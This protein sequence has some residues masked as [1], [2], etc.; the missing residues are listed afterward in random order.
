MDSAFN[1]DKSELRVLVLL[2]AVQVLSH[3]DS[4]LDQHVQ[5]LRDG[6]GK[7]YEEMCLGQKMFAAVV[8]PCKLNLPD[9]LRILRILLPVTLFT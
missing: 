3:G 5:I 7:A 8:S 1:Q 9:F 2:V 4:L 6:R